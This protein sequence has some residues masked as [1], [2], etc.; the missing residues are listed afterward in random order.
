MFEMDLGP[1]GAPGFSMNERLDFSGHN[2]TTPH[3]NTDIVGPCGKVGYSSGP[4]GAANFRDITN[5]QLPGFNGMQAPPVGP[6]M[7][8]IGP[9]GPHMM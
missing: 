1:Y 4:Y 9:I 3:L 2:N 6:Q 5:T 8:G 7:P